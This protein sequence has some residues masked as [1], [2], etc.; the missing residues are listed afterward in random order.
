MFALKSYNMCILI[1]VLKSDDKIQLYC[2]MHIL[3]YFHKNNN[4]FEEFLCLF[5]FGELNS[6]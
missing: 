3:V 4:Q 6:V 2:V 5:Q 1:N